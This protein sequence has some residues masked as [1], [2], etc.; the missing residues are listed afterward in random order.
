[1]MTACKVE[2]RDSPICSIMTLI[3]DTLLS[4]CV[5]R[6]F[7]EKYSHDQQATVYEKA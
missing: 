6:F 2:I 3:A 5:L 1:M 7:N 4:F